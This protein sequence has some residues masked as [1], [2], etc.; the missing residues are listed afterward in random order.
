MAGWMVQRLSAEARRR[1]YLC[2]P[3]PTSSLR[4]LS[5]G[6]RRRGS[7]ITAEGEVEAFQARLEA[8]GNSYDT[9]AM[10]DI[11]RNQYGRRHRI[12]NY[13]ASGS[14]R[15][16]SCTADW[17][18]AMLTEQDD[19]PDLELPEVAIAGRS[20]CGKSSLVNALCG[21][22]PKRFGSASTSPRV[23]SWPSKPR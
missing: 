17:M 23:R 22:N 6:T 12:Y 19:V 15:K 7:V 16:V 20:N 14:R 1:L 10:A 13:K 5:G 2:S 18:A 11:E 9:D 4:H 21:V 3:A 8:I